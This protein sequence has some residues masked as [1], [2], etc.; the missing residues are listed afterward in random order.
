MSKKS[1]LILWAVCLS[2][3]VSILKTSP[4]QAQSANEN[5]PE[6]FLMTEPDS[7]EYLYA[8]GNGKTLTS[9]IAKAYAELSRKIEA[10][11]EALSNQFTEESEGA[12]GDNEP[13]YSSAS[14]TVTNQTIG[15]VSISAMQQLEEAEYGTSTG[16]EYMAKFTN[17]C[18]VI[19]TDDG[20]SFKID[21]YESEVIN[22]EESN[23]STSEELIENGSS[24][25]TFVNY[26]NTTKLITPKTE[27]VSVETGHEYFVELRLSLDEI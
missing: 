11:V 12:E 23:L 24:F 25:S 13:T 27:S 15:K 10:K 21:F 2:A 16:S 7:D 5:V 1:A 3:V 20:G 19:F 14:K 18:R 17:L 26:L 6:W 4:V 9:A 8:Y 22:G